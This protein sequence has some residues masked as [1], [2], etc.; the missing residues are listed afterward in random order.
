MVNKIKEET[1]PFNA[2]FPKWL[3][4]K[5]ISSGQKEKRNLT[6]EVIYRLEKSYEDKH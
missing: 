6:G 4:K 2:R 1:E 3:K 5:L